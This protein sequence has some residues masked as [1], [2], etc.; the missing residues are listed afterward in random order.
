MSST[1]PCRRRPAKQQFS[2]R[3][4]QP[5]SPATHSASR[6]TSVRFAGSPVRD[7]G[8]RQLEQR[9][10]GGHPLDE[11]AQRRAR[12]G[13][14][15]RCRARRTPSPGRSCPSA[16]AR[17]GPPSP[18]ARAARGRWRRSRSCPSR[19]PSISAWRSASA[20]ERRVHLHARVH[21]A[22]V[23]LGQQQVVGR[24]LGAD[25]ASRGAWRRATASTEAAQLRC[26]KCTRASSYPA[27]S[28]SR[29]TIVDSPTRGDPADAER[30]ADRA[31]VHGAAARERRVL[32]V[33]G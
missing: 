29:A 12:R 8:R 14:R 26:W 11:Q 27:S 18:R 20:G 6:S 9:R 28:A 4:S 32:L 30:R 22:H 10:A 2:E 17:T 24:D 33:Q 31:L 5:R 7:R 16:P 3:L 23:L 19:R 15:A 25:A 21:T 13:A 1:R